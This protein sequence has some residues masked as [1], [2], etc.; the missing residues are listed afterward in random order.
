[1]KIASRKKA[2][3][4]SANGRPITSPNSDIMPGHSRPISKLSIVPDTAP[5][6]NRTAETL[7]HFF[8][9]TSASCIVV[10]EA[11]PMQ[12]VDQRREGHAEARQDDV[13]TERE[14]HLVA[15]GHQFVGSEQHREPPAQTVSANPDPGTSTT[16]RNPLPG[17]LN[18][19]PQPSTPSP[20]PQRRDP[21]GF[22]GVEVSGSRCLGSRCLGVEVGSGGQSARRPAIRIRLNA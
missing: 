22:Q 5:T 3:P 17:G 15:G 7:A 8:A 13:E 10:L 20:N 14:R 4:S 12:H 6:A 18:P 2:M 19:D 21:P 9:S 1:M 11:A 16:W